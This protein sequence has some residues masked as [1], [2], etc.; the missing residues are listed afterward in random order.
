MQFVAASLR[1]AGRFV[2]YG[3]YKID[4]QHTAESNVAF[5]QWLWGQNPEYG[6]RDV[7]DVVAEARLNRLGL[8]E[9]VAMPANNFCSCSRSSNPLERQ[10]ASRHC[11]GRQPF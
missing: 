4:G 1:S 5:E 2:M 6:V 7:A 9:R 3:P 11:R 10:G 8:I